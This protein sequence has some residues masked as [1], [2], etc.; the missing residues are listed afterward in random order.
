ML[1]IFAAIFGIAWGGIETS[2][3]PMT[4][5][6][7]G[8]KSH[9]IVFGTISLAFT[10]GAAIGPIVTGYIFDTTGEYQVA[11]IIMAILGIIGIGFTSFLKGM[12]KS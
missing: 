5:W 9:P 10:V 12:A 4:A 6:L 7:F 11:F 8:L 2:E 3:S 1:F